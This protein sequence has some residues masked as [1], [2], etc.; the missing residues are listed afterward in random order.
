[1]IPFPHRAIDEVR[2]FLSVAEPEV[3]AAGR[4]AELVE[5]FCE[6]ERLAVAGKLLFA[7]RAAESTKWA[8]EGHRSPEAWLADASGSSMGEAI[9]AIQ[10]ADRLCGLEK[11]TKALRKGQLSQAQAK[12][13]ECHQCLK[14]QGFRS[15]SRPHRSTTGVYNRGR[16]LRG[17]SITGTAGDRLVRGWS[18]WP[19]RGDLDPAT[20]RGSLMT[21]DPWIRLATA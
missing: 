15:A 16:N 6:L 2:E 19:C 14:A 1:M 12:A 9:S 20:R 4:A 5:A 21:L 11:T 18:S 3:V 8:T 17:Q 7:A 13:R 10:T